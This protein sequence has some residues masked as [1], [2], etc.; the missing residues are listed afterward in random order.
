MNWSVVRDDYNPSYLIFSVQFVDPLKSLGVLFRQD[1]AG[2]HDTG[3]RDNNNNV[4]DC[5][6]NDLLYNELKVEARTSKSVG[7]R[8]AR[9][10]HNTHPISQVGHL[11]EGFRC[12]SL[13]GLI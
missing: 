3:K 13:R 7:C 5:L 1:H 4:N 9:Y 8:R 6:I 12:N 11:S 10:A 2:T